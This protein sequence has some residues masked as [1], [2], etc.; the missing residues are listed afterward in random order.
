MDKNLLKRLIDEAQTKLDILKIQ[1]PF[2]QRKNLKE[3][4]AYI[5]NTL[6]QIQGN[7]KEL[8]EYLAYLR[9]L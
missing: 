8:E 6:G 9:E 3:S 4:S 1:E 7:I 5:L 2:W